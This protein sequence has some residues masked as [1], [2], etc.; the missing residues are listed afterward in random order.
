[1]FYNTL[2]LGMREVA[3]AS[4]ATKSILGDVAAHLRPI[5]G[6]YTLRGRGQGRHVGRTTRTS[7]PAPNT[8]GSG[9]G[10]MMVMAMI[11]LVMV[12]M[13]RIEW[14]ERERDT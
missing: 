3:I 11:C 8:T 12:M 7:I 5:I 14:T 6:R 2:L 4:I 10:G 9:L 13:V 1:M